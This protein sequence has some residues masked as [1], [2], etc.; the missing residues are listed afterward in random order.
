MAQLFPVAKK[1]WVGPFLA[2]QD[3]NPSHGLVS[4]ALL[5]RHF[6]YQF[7]LLFYKVLFEVSHK[8]AGKMLLNF[9]YYYYYI[10]VF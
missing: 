9:S 2:L 6:L 5:H 4:P 1:L 8:A 7:F 10:N 3:S